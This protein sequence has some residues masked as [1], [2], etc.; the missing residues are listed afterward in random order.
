MTD[1]PFPVAMRDLLIEHDYATKSGTP[2]WSSFA[3]VARGI[4]YETLRRA[5]AG[6]RSPSPKLMEECA[7]AL[8]LR[9]EYFLEYRLYLAQRS[10]DPNAVG[11]EHAARNL[12]LWSRIA[13]AAS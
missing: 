4:H 5:I 3:E 1:D 8:R 6:E 11:L 13:D 9:P 12:E 2:N 7:R 10:F